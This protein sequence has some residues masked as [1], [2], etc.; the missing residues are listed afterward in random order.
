MS[1]NR[2]RIV[3]RSDSAT[4]SEDEESC[5]CSRTITSLWIG[6][7]CKRAITPVLLITPQVT[8]RITHP[9]TSEP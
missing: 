3:P 1:G 5:S 9:S 6:S 2:Q 4:Q 7:R 8:S